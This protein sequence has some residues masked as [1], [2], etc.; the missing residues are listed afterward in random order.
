MVTQYRGTE[1]K[2]M[3]CSGSREY[4]NL[5]GFAL[6]TMN[7]YLTGNCTRET[8]C[9]IT[10]PSLHK[11]YEVSVQNGEYNIKPLC[12]IETIME[13]DTIDEP[14]FRDMYSK[15]FT[16]IFGISDVEI[17]D[18]NGNRL[19][20]NSCALTLAPQGTV[21]AAYWEN[22]I[23]YLRGID[24][25]N[26]EIYKIRD[27]TLPFISS[28]GRNFIGDSFNDPQQERM[29][30]RLKLPVIDSYY[31]SI[32]NITLNAQKEKL[33][34]YVRDYKSNKK[35]LCFVDINGNNLKCLEIEQ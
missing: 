23:R 26:N 9:H 31:S 15:S 8:I 18:G 27:D 16:N 20:M 35:S 4:E 2:G 33:A 6:G 17:C 10:K 34:F 29:V 1:K 32:E 24:K 3:D 13:G 12:T 25:N 11:L 30:K 28:A 5:N 22:N 21:F 7:N 14:P 19:N